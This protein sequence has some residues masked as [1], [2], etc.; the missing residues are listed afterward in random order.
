MG[1]LERNEVTLLEYESFHSCGFVDVVA[2]ASSGVDSCANWGFKLA[3][4][5][6]LF[7]MPKNPEYHMALLPKGQCY[8]SSSTSP[9]K[10]ISK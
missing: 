10:P 6:T 4:Y 3:G 1:N 2:S 8:K 5:L 7:D 9:T